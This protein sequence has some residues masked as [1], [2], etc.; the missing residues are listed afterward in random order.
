MV[1]ILMG[2][3]AHV[4][5]TRDVGHVYFEWTLYVHAV[6]H[7]H[8]DLQIQRLTP[9]KR[10]YETVPD[11]SLWARAEPSHPNI[12]PVETFETSKFFVILIRSN[13]NRGCSE[14]S[15]Y[16][17]FVHSYSHNDRH[18]RHCN[19]IF[20]RLQ[21]LWNGGCQHVF[22]HTKLVSYWWATG[23]WKANWEIGC[24]YWHTRQRV[25]FHQTRRYNRVC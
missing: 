15:C 6:R 20:L 2:C 22:R 10:T 12:S 5:S 18:H 14:F 21:I 11:M 24:L 8:I 16:F 19:V 17:E 7:V 25:S 1:A 9:R 4:P 3:L 13:Y 23:E